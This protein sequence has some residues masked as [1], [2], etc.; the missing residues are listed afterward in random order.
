MRKALAE[1][2][3]FSIKRAFK[4]ENSRPGTTIDNIEKKDP[5]NFKLGRLFRG[6][7]FFE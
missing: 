6:L 4:K 5:P 1:P 7:R 2:R 3:A